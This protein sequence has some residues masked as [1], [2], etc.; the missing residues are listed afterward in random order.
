MAETAIRVTSAVDV[1]EKG[2]RGNVAPGA[3]G[4]AIPFFLIVVSILQVY[5]ATI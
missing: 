5:A 4:P 1:E 2:R 3:H